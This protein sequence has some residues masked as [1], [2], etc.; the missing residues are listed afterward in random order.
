MLHECVTALLVYGAYGYTGE[1]VAAELCARGHDPV[2]A[3][4]NATK[5]DRIGTRLGCDTRAFPVGAAAA[6]LDG[7]DVVL[8]C[9][10]PFTET[11]TPLADACLDAGVDYLDIT[12][13]I[14]VFE[15]LARRDDDAR[16]ADATLLPGVGFDVVPTDCLAAHLAQRLPDATHL[17]LGFEPHGGISPGTAATAVGQLGDGGAVRR[18]G[19]LLSV[20]PAHRQ[21]RIDFGTGTRTAVTFPWG[22]VATAFRS[23]GIPNVEVY[24]PMPSAARRALRAS[25]HLAPLFDAAP[26]RDTLRSLITRFVDGPDADER[27]TGRAHI[28]GE[29]SSDAT[30]ETAV[31]RLVTP[32]TYA[33]TVDA[34]TT[35]AE[36]TLDGD[37]PPG[38][39]TPATAFGA[40]F[41]TDLDGVTRTDDGDA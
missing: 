15:T 2:L 21:R 20:P 37:T 29:V 25:G 28:W 27:A 35:A 6:H 4:R 40:D 10:G 23:T 7:V 22:D 14:P 3:G 12:G 17:A 31:S 30:G 38:Y 34:A 1:L 19:R 39:Q 13:E 9:A 18:D 41:V 11:A 33:F 32:E 8:N 24:I 36:R 5:L 16:D 26:V